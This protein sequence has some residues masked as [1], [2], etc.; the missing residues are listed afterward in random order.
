M[1]ISRQFTHH[2]KIQHISFKHR[3]AAFLYHL[4]RKHICIC[5]SLHILFQAC[6]FLIN[7]Y[8]ED[9]EVILKVTELENPGKMLENAVCASVISKVSH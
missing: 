7:V 6:P 2:F 4:Q 5:L 9:G 8:A 1:T 3:I